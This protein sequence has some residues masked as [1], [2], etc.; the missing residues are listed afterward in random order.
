MNAAI[1]EARKSNTLLTSAGVPPA[2][3]WHHGLQFGDEALVVEVGVYEGGADG[4]GCHRVDSHAYRR[5][6][7]C[8]LL[9]QLYDPVL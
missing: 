7:G 8:E 1:G 9:G 2:P 5:K 6:V 3:T 4:D